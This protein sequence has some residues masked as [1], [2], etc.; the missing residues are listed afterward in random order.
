MIISLP[1]NITVINKTHQASAEMK[2]I[3]VKCDIVLFFFFVS[4]DELWIF[5]Q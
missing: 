4:E 5:Y 2:R 1:S 3:S